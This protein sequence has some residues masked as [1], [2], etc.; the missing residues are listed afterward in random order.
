MATC[1]L[2][3]NICNTWGTYYY[4]F[5]FSNK[6]T[7]DQKGKLIYVRS[8]IHLVAELWR[9]WV[10]SP[11]LKT[12]LGY[13]FGS[14]NKDPNKKECYYSVIQLSVNNL[15][16]PTRL[17]RQ[18]QSCK[19]PRSISLVGAQLMFSRS[20]CFP[21]VSLPIITSWFQPPGWRKGRRPPC[22]ALEP[23]SRSCIHLFCSH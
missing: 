15:N 17:I 21:V 20:Q 12:P 22:F 1:P 4:Q 5:Y 6:G 9:E 3:F 10:R 16:T 18:F 2:L 7:K 8:Y 23:Q 11:M 14:Y 19:D 13:E